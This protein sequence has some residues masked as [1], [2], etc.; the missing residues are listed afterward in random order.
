MKTIELEFTMSFMYNKI[1][2]EPKI[3]PSGT[4]YEI[5]KSEELLS[6]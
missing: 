1:N 4:P 3:E 5:G 2:G 6:L